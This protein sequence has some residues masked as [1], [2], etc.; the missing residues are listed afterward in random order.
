MKPDWWPK[1]TVDI[2][3]AIEGFTEKLRGKLRDL[4]DH[5]EKILRRKNPYLLA[6]RQ[7]GDSVGFARHM[8][9]AF[10][11]SS[12]ETLFGTIF[13]Q[14]AEIVCGCF[15]GYNT[16]KLF[17]VLCLLHPDDVHGIVIANHAYQLLLF[18]ENRHGY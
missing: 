12:E 15:I 7:S 14:C 1:A 16:H 17:H 8:V 3:Q 11:S 18:I 13:D 2:D 4:G 9:D 5:P 6:I 10:I